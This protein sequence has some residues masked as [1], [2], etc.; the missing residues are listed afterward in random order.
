MLR[1]LFTVLSVLSLMLCVGTVALEVLSFDVRDQVF[2]AER[3]GRLWW[4][5]S[6]RGR[7]EVVFAERWPV[8]EPIQHVR[9]PVRSFKPR[10]YTAGQAGA[11]WSWMGMR[12]MKGTG[13]I[14]VLT[15]GP[16][17]LNDEELAGSVPPHRSGPIALTEDPWNPWLATS[18]PGGGFR[19][20]SPV[21]RV[22][23]VS[24]PHALAAAA[25]AV[26]P[27][28]WMVLA[29]RRAVARLRRVRRG[30]CRGCGY[31]LTANVSGTCPECGERV[32]GGAP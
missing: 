13:Y 3:G 15:T 16:P 32:S 29:A 14:N 31:N 26:P 1:R 9:V 24:I 5:V 19:V 10:E 6:E 21:L 23:A 12:G 22:W 2:A 25:F 28:A 18:D 7:V 4:A 27:A 8:S 20:T 11:Y 30:L 17:F